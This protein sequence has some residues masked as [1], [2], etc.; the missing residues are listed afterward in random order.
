[1][2]GI[3]WKK[4]QPRSRNYLSGLVVAVSGKPKLAMSLLPWAGYILP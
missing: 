1:M 4:S 2:L 3:L